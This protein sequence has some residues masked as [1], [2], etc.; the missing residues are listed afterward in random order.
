MEKLPLDEE[1]LETEKRRL[2]Y[3]CIK[4]WKE[5]KYTLHSMCLQFPTGIGNAV[6]SFLSK[7]LQLLLLCIKKRY[8]GS[9]RFKNNPVVRG[10]EELICSPTQNYLLLYKIHFSIPSHM[11]SSTTAMLFKSSRW[12]T[13]LWSLNCNCIYFTSALS[14]AIRFSTEYFKDTSEPFRTQRN[15]RWWRGEE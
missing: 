15:K 13:G 2:N 3:F 10:I 1:K 6:E 12:Q 4:G 14:Y 11:S 5:V 7:V 8:F 9:L